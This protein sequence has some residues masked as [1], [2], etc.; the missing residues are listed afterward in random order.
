MV[1]AHPA[2]LPQAGDA[3]AGQLCRIAFDALMKRLATEHGPP[4]AEV[5]SQYNPISLKEAGRR[6]LRAQLTSRFPPQAFR[7][8]WR[9]AP[10][11]GKAE[12]PGFVRVR[13]LP[14]AN[15]PLLRALPAC[16]ARPASW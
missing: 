15:G 14:S 16:R 4:F 12:N 2:P 11:D 6:Q 3:D 8:N 1:D 13:E 7:S 9:V 5:L 10:S